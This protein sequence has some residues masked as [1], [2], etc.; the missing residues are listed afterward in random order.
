[1]SQAGV[2]A[3]AAQP[4]EAH[5]AESQRPVPGVPA[6]PHE[7]HAEDRERAVLRA[8]APGGGDQEERPGGSCAHTVHTQCTHACPCMSPLTQ[9]SSWLDSTPKPGSCCKADTFRVLSGLKT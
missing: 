7:G 9:P 2:G 1:M 5:V 3:A 6:P 8:A 4:A